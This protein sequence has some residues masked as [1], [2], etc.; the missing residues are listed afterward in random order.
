MV[1]SNQQ[2]TQRGL[3]TILNHSLQITFNPVPSD[4]CWFNLCLSLTWRPFL[5]NSVPILRQKGSAKNRMR[6]ALDWIWT[7]QGIS[8]SIW[9]T[10]RLQDKFWKHNYQIMRQKILLRKGFII[11]VESE[12]V[13]EQSGYWGQ[14]SSVLS[15]RGEVSVS[16]QL[17]E[18]TDLQQFKT[19][20]VWPKSSLFCMFCFLLITD[21]ERDVTTKAKAIQGDHPHK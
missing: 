16:N 21:K 6:V 20:K 12:S 11:F 8:S 10:S 7:K 5:T 15:N 1:P 17:L 3:A 4:C 9:N 18:Q 13:F 19:F 2:C 14:T